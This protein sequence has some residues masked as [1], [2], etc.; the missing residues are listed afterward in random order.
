MEKQT[1][2]INFFAGPGAGKSTMATGLFYKLKSKGINCE[3]VHEFAKD[4]V[5]SERRK[6][7]ENQL[8]VLGE[9]FHRQHRL[10]G[11]TDIAI[12]DSPILLSQAYTKN[13]MPQS[14]QTLIIDLHKMFNNKN[15]LIERPQETFQQEGRIHNLNQ[16]KELDQKIQSILNKSNIEYE[17][18][19]CSETSIEKIY[20]DII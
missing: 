14:L 16:S 1:L 20:K 19:P 4:L 18:V 17:T 6:D 7:L 9:Q 5:W 12:C 3:L 8:F 2:F 10:K 15:Y 11:K 13:N